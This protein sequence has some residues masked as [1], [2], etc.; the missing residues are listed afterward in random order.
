MV[1]T[2]PPATEVVRQIAPWQ[3]GVLVA[4]PVVALAARLL[5]TPWYQNDDDTPD[6]ARVLTEIAGSTV[7]NDIGAVLTMVSGMLYVAAAVVL[8]LWVRSRMPRTATAGL[9][10][11]SVGGFGLV[12]FGDQL[13]IIGQAARLEEHRGAM[14]ALL[15]ASYDS[16]QAGI[17]YLLLVLGALGWVLLGV[18][19]YRGRVVPRAAAVIVALGGAGVMV[20][21]PGPAVSFIAGAAV[22]SL[23]G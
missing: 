8:G 2:S 20:T 6:N 21:A 14:I 18:V 17:S 19:L 22:I 12:A 3:L 5:N 9:V 7:A 11:A 1:Q 4:A 16:P 10:L 13:M 23:V 15:Q